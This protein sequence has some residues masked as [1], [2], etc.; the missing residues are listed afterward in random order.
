MVVGHHA[1]AHRRGEERQLRL[2]DECAHLVLGARGGHALA[3][4]HQRPFGRLQYVQRLL[5]VLRHRLHA[6]RIRAFRG[7][8]RLVGVAPAGNDVVSNIEIG[9]AGPAVDRLPD[10]HLHVER[11]AVHMFDGV[12]P[13]AQW[14]RGQY[15]TLFLESAHA[16]AVGLRRATDQQHR[17]A[18]LL[19]VREARETVDDAWTGHDDA[20]AW[21]AGQVAD[22]AGGIRC[23]LL[24]AHTDIGK[25]HLLRCLGERTNREP[26]HAEHELYALF[27]EAFRQQVG[28]FD[29]SHVS[30]CHR[31]T[32]I[33]PDTKKSERRSHYAYIAP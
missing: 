14:R 19:R 9:G 18:I 32:T 11:D 21:A 20:R 7:L 26:D 25:A 5:D 15:L 13:F 10:R 4:D 16:V 8:D 28:A 29:L 12:R 6:R 24:V 1:L 31:V 3:D 2:L 22:G 33:G 30:S 27:L 17:P 23:G